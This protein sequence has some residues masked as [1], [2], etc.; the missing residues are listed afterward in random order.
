MRLPSLPEFSILALRLGLGT[1]PTKGPKRLETYTFDVTYNLSPSLDYNTCNNAFYSTLDPS[2]TSI[3]NYTNISTDTGSN[4][5]LETAGRS[6]TRIQISYTPSPENS[7][8][9]FWALTE[10]PAVDTVC[11]V[12]KHRN[13]KE[14][15]AELFVIPGLNPCLTARNKA[16]FQNAG[17]EAELKFR[18]EACT[19]TK[20]DLLIEVLKDPSNGYR[21]P[22][23]WDEIVAEIGRRAGPNLENEL[24]ANPKFIFD[25]P[26]CYGKYRSKDL[27]SFPVAV[28]GS[29]R[30]P[31]VRPIRRIYA[32]ARMDSG[33]HQKMA[34][35]VQLS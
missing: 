16:E 12:S 11:L 7:Q 27:S 32:N 22:E 4:L 15:N 2:W 25:E 13:S 28:L 35:D 21:F 9:D 33:R 24:R 30:V 26:E 19:R 20:V 1:L 31:A 14:V 3:S 17:R 5:E 6:G 18:T 8:A 29:R 23:Q 34:R 10:S